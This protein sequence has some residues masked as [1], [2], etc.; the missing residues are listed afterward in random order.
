M[1]LF[2]FGMIFFE[3]IMHELGKLLLLLDLYG[4]IECVHVALNPDLLHVQ[5]KD[6]LVRHHVVAHVHSLAKFPIDVW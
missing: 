6:L 5:V 2:M 1:Y 4:S 3:L